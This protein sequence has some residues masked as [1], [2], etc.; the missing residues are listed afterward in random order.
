MVNTLLCFISSFEYS[1]FSA[2]MHRL[3]PATVD[4]FKY[5]DL[6]YT[7]IFL[8]D[9]LLTLI[10]KHETEEAENN[11]LGDRNEKN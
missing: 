11:V 3:Q 6:I 4:F 8:I 7:I 2:F 10:Q 9:L 5:R 1:F